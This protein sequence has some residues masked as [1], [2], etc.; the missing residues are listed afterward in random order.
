MPPKPAKSQEKSEAD[1]A[2]VSKSE[3]IAILSDHRSTL[4]TELKISFNELNEKL[5]G[6]QETVNSHD[7]RLTS[8]EEN[9]ESLHR[10]LEKVE[11]FCDTVQSD[12]R[13]LF[14]IVPRLHL[15]I[16]M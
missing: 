2:A 11:A 3:L 13:K 8:L 7:N 6:L 9:A 10:R 15:Q 1:A 16:R 4:L 14:L 12:N 5:D